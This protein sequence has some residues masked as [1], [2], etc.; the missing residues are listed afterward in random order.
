MF[1]RTSRQQDNLKTTILQI[2]TYQVIPHKNLKVLTFL[3]RAD[4]AVRFH[5]IQFVILLLSHVLT[6]IQIQYLQLFTSALLCIMHLSMLSPRGGGAN[7]W[8]LT[9]EGVTGVGKFTI[10]RG[11]RVGEFDMAAMLNNWERTYEHDTQP[12]TRY[13]RWTKEEI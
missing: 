1:I 11:P 4:N 10:L 2:L 7:P 13:K 5:Y 3:A 8:E 12:Q 9:T 6:G